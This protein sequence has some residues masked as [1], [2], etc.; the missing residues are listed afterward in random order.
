M[1]ATPEPDQR[2]DTAEA[3]EPTAPQAD[4][5]NNATAGLSGRE[6]L[7]RTAVVVVSYVFYLAERPA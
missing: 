7:S 3:T 1:T 6:L 4:E 2:T 5:S